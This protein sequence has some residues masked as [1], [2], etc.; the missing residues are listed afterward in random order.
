MN[1][2]YIPEGIFNLT[3][4]VSIGLTTNRFV[5]PILFWLPSIF[6]SALFEFS[7]SPSIPEQFKDIRMSKNHHQPPNEGSATLFD[8]TDEYRPEEVA[9]LRAEIADQKQVI[10]SCVHNSR[11]CTSTW[12]GGKAELTGSALRH[13]ISLG[14][15]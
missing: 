9:N 12:I 1:Y 13:P 6:V 4:L 11:R 2:S 10:I 5:M 15:R 14:V 3:L 8:K 7:A